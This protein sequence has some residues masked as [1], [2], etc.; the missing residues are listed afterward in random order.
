MSLRTKIFLSLAAMVL[1]T[2][3]LEGSLDFL[4]S[5]GRTVLAAQSENQVQLTASA[6]A[7]S[8]EL[9]GE[10]PVLSGVRQASGSGLRATRYR[11][12][13]GD[14]VIQGGRRAFPVSGEGWVTATRPLMAGMTLEVALEKSPLE[15]FLENEL[16]VDLVDLPIFLGLAFL[17]SWLL[18]RALTRPIQQLTV[19]SEQLSQQKFPEPLEVPPGEDELS[20]MA[21]SFNAM[22]ESIHG[23]L[24]RE[25]ALTRYASHELR[26]PLASLRAQVESVQA[27]LATPESVIPRLERN[28]NR[29]QGIISA[30]LSLSRA[31][32]LNQ[33]P[34]P[35][36]PLISE[37]VRTVPESERSRLTVEGEFRAVVV[38]DARLV[39]QAVANLVDNALQHTAGRVSLSVGVSGP[40]LTIEV[41]DEGPGLPPELLNGRSG[42]LTDRAVR[43]DGSGLGL[44]LVE[45][46]AS[47]LEGTLRLTNM[48]EGQGLCATLTLPVAATH[49]SRPRE[50]TPAS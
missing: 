48:R 37:F 26:T 47:S 42:H 1:I 31:S 44:S 45:R 38:T 21:R 17:I 6:L 12:L 2:A 10:V 39:Q 25:R 29:L 41:R 15:R 3:V 16:L 4:A 11:I 23:Y 32:D 27:G 33:D 13:R 19:A 46:I 30:L 50:A 28:I 40:D 18:S 36:T 8:I 14:E 20:R 9:R 5:R 34:M 35:L 24:D 43:P 7:A 22:S 49:D